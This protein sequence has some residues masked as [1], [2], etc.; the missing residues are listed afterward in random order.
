[1][2]ISSFCGATSSMRSMLRSTARPAVQ[3]G[4]KP[5]RRLL[6]L[7]AQEGFTVPAAKGGP[8]DGASGD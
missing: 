1:M 7:A 3:K 6:A 2:R 8:A 4:R 5:K